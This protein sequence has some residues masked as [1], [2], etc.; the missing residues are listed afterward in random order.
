[1]IEPR[2]DWHW[3]FGL[4]VEAERGLSPRDHHLCVGEAW[5]DFEPNVW[6]GVTATLDAE[7]SDD[8]DAALYRRHEHAKYLLA[9]AG[10]SFPDAAEGPGWVARLV[11]AADA[12]PIARS[13]PAKPD[14][15][16]VI[17]GYPWFNDWGRDTMIALPGLTLA[18][19]Q[20]DRA[21]RILETFAKFADR[22]MLPNVFPGAGE[23]ADYNT[24]DAAL[25]F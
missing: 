23:R 9:R 3:N 8:L 2:R 7:I 24:A 20:Y 4:P 21:R 11:L 25:W 15:E 13:L 16:S 19:G 12:Y 18:T 5:L 6:T 17:A 14:G 1:R 22:G 10:S